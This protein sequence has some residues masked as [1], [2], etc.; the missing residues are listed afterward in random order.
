MFNHDP[1]TT[2]FTP[3]Y[4][5]PVRE[6]L[7]V[8]RVSSVDLALYSLF[9]RFKVLEDRGDLSWVDVCQMEE[10]QGKRPSSQGGD[11]ASTGELL[12]TDRAVVEC[13]AIDH[14]IGVIDGPLR[15]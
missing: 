10:E 7:G 1:V 14:P 3:V 5:E 9:N 13:V 6:S 2:G 12:I 11:I 4:D 15:T 8:D